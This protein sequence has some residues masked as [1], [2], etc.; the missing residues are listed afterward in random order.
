[1][2]IWKQPLASASGM[3]AEFSSGLKAGSIILGSLI[4]LGLALWLGETG[5]LA[6]GLGLL[7]T[8]VILFLAK[9]NLGGITG[10]VLGM[11]IELVEV[12][13]LLAFSFGG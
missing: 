11:I 2:L 7:V 9:K 1:M 12:A 3:G 13:V 10:D 6:I 8:L 5:F 4:P